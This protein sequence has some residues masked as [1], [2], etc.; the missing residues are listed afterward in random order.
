MT[1][2]STVW[3]RELQARQGPDVVGGTEGLELVV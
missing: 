2:C 3:S 1:T